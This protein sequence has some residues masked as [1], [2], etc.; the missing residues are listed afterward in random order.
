M[1]IWEHETEGEVSTFTIP[2]TSTWPEGILSFSFYSTT[3]TS[4]DA[5]PR[6]WLLNASMCKDGREQVGFVQESLGG[7]DHAE[8]TFSC[9]NLENVEVI[10]GQIDEK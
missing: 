3:T 1:A 6:P 8:V 5:T 7:F 2:Y 9:V 4:I 10:L